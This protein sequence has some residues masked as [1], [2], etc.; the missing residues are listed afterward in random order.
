ME[1]PHDASPAIEEL[2]SY[3][4]DN[5]APLLVAD[6]VESLLQHPEMTANGIRT[7]VASHYSAL[8]GR[9]TISSLVFH[10]VRKIHLL[11]ELKV[12]PRAPLDQ[13]LTQLTPFLVANVPQEERESLRINLD[14]VGESNVVVGG[15]ALQLHQAPAGGTGAPGSTATGGGSAEDAALTTEMLR[16]LRRFAL[17]L[18]QSGAAQSA[19]QGAMGA[20][21]APG[22]PGAAPA[23]S[24][25]PEAAAQMLAAAVETARN[26]RE[27]EQYLKR[28]GLGEVGAGTMQ[29]LSRSLPAWV[30]HDGDRVSAYHGSSAQAMQR[31][32]ALAGDPAKSGERFREMVRSAVDQINDGSLARAMA[33]LEL[34]QRVREEGTVDPRVADLVLGSAHDALDAGRLL[35]LARDT[36]Q[37]PLLSKVLQFFPALQPGALLDAV[38]NEPD[39]QRR[40]LQLALLELQGPA[41]R[42]LALDRL[43]ASL[44][45]EPRRPNAWWNERNYVYLLHVIPPPPNALPEREVAHVVRL[46]SLENAAPLIRESIIC[47]GQARH[48]RSLPTLET[49]LREVEAQLLQEG[50]PTLHSAPELRRFLGLI[51]QALARS[52]TSTGRRAV[53]EHALRVDPRLGDT[54]PRLAELQSVDLS[55]D[56]ESVD[57]LLAALRAAIPVKVFGMTIKRD[58][59]RA[60]VILRALSATPSPAVRQGLAE[61]AR[62]FS[63]QSFGRLAAEILRGFSA[64]LPTPA[65]GSAPASTSTAAPAARPVSGLAG[66]LEVFGLPEL[67]QSLSQSE[68]SGILTLRDRGGR[69]ISTLW[70]RKGT[71]SRAR[72]GHLSGDSAFYQLLERPTP[73]TFEF[74]RADLLDATGA[75]FAIGSQFMPLL[76]EA[77]RRYDELQRARALIADHVHL[78]PTG[79]RPTAPPDETDGVF[80]RDMWTKVKNGATPAECDAAI[81]A[82]AYR[83]RS[84]LAYWLEE[85]VVQVEGQTA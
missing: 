80:V 37:R 39:R 22:G 1:D 27:L 34:A 31:L 46:S 60:E 19:P 55:Q 32:V 43:E 20:A 67:V 23:A 47:L 69:E 6:S 56:P 30:L 68:A 38:S 71:L 58:S 81:D 41:V 28:A 33:I 75:G 49:R 11:G 45:E 62:R 70:L 63:E 52:A 48:E 12:V 24:A 66:D 17:M 25:S 59:E 10:A 9:T 2:Y 8:G 74:S 16:G 79:A 42:E 21:G 36:E 7:W 14:H 35:T 78:R 57:R 54:L 15:A 3:L 4:S 85:G 44:A 51:V 13:F 64:P 53:I 18:E 40:R 84:L 82:D 77:M 26:S 29:A 65:P 72:T 76:M 61:I 83:V 5:L 73:G 50:G